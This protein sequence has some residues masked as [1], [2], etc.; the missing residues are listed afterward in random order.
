M[1]RQ[2]VGYEFQ[3]YQ[4][5]RLQS[6]AAKSRHHLQSGGLARCV[7]KRINKIRFFNDID[8]PI[9]KITEVGMDNLY[10]NKKYEY[11]PAIQFPYLHQ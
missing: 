7:T 2:R 6:Q 5:I 4:R 11:N 3:H 1:A 9:S 10:T 8:I